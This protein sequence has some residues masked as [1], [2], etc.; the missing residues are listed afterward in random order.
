M[1]A[2]FMLGACA[3]Q[4]GTRFLVAKECHVHANYKAKVIKAKDTDTIATGK[5]LGHPV[6]ALKTPF[7][8]SFFAKEYDPSVSNEELESLGIGALKSA[9]LAG[10]EQ[11]GCFMAGQSAGLVTKEQSVKEII[12]ELCGQAGQLLKGASLWVG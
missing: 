7:T 10:D 2:A 1:A 9:V 4:L 6:R 12:E 3:V 11:N 5:R 8:R